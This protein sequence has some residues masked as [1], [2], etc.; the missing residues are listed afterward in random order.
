MNL[1]M[2]YV[3]LKEVLGVTTKMPNKNTYGYKE[4]GIEELFG[5]PPFAVYDSDFVPVNISKY[6]LDKIQLTHGYFIPSNGDRVWIENSSSKKI[7]MDKYEGGSHIAI[8]LGEFY[9]RMSNS[10]KVAFIDNYDI[11]KKAL[12]G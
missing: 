3:T 6:V 5:L 10:E 9:N 1:W 4:Y 12:I 7:H 11:I 2:R 8:C